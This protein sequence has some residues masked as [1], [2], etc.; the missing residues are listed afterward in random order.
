[1]EIINDDSVIITNPSDDYLESQDKQSDFKESTLQ[2]I[3]SCL[4]NK[5]KRYDIRETSQTLG[6]RQRRFFEV[7]GVFE[8]IGICQKIDPDS[9]MWVGFGNVKTKI[10]NIAIQYGAFHPEYTLNDIFSNNGKISVQRITEEFLLLFIALELRRIN[11][12]EAAKYL[13]RNNDKQKTTRCKLYQVAAV[14]EIAKV[15][16]KTENISE[17]ELLPEYFISISQKYVPK[18]ADPS[19]LLTLLNRP[20]PFYKIDANIDIS[21]RLS[22][23][24]SQ[25]L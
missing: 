5:Q 14:L 15:I 3:K 24:Y 13:S 21:S 10:E 12:I 20:E 23:Y 17:Y 11:V 25:I 16:K 19:L 8:A 7:I 9:F 1:M 2:F 4:V 22:E 6:F 18:I